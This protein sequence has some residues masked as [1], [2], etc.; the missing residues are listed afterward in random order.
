MNLFANMNMKRTVIVDCD[1]VL[2]ETSPRAVQLLHEDYDFFNQFFRLID[3]FDLQK[4]TPLINSRPVYHLN[5]WLLRKEVQ[6]PELWEAY[7]NECMPKFLENFA[8]PDFYEPLGLTYL[9][10]SLIRLLQSGTIT[11]VIIISKVTVYNKEGIQGKERFL[12]TM[13]AGFM[14]RVD[15]Y[16]LPSDSNYQKSDVINALPPH[17]LAD[18]AFFADDHISNIQ[19]VLENTKLTDYQ[20]VVPSYGYNTDISTLTQPKLKTKNA[21]LYFYS[22]MAETDY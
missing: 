10:H 11:R 19:D 16:Y 21:S 20:L 22:P 13:F 5:E 1:E 7:Q 3:N 9:G 8:R 6:D 15:I 17:V 2:V 12:K 18:V 14:D 4:V